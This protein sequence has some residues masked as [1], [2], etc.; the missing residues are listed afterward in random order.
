MTSESQRTFLSPRL[1]SQASSLKPGSAAGLSLVELLIAIGILGVTM[2]LIGAAFPAGVMMSIAVSDET[3]GQSVFQQAVGVI[4][5][6]YSVGE[7]EA[8]KTGHA[9]A[10]DPPGSSEYGLVGDVYLGKDASDD[11]DPDEGEDNRI[12]EFEEDQE[13]NFSWSV[14]MKRMG[15]SGP[16]GNLCQLVVVV[17]R[18]PSG[19]PSFNKQGGGTSAL[20]ELR[21][22]NCTG[23]EPDAR[24][25]TIGTGSS[26]VPNDGYIIDGTTGTAYIIVSRDNNT[27]VTLGTPPSGAA[28][29]FWVVPGPN[30]G[31]KPPAIRV[32]QVMLYLP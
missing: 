3:T 31:P 12:Y 10:P 8:W 18:R 14:L 17:S 9:S 1:R 30:N 2:M 25:L 4:R 29:D 32:F 23:S 6:N 21:S 7:A 28:G 20:P 13:S 27:V 24:T 15:T 26:L 19:S 22:V 5:D 11:Y 16:M